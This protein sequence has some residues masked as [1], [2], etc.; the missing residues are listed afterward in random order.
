MLRYVENGKETIDGLYRPASGRAALAKLD[1]QLIGAYL[2]GHA[3][4]EH[5]W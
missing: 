3:A 5:R 2:A 1:R 4:G